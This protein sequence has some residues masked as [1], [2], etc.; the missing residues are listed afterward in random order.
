VVSCIQGSAITFIGL[1]VD[2]DDN[3]NDGDDESYYSLNF[4]YPVHINLF[5]IL[6]T[7]GIDVIVDL[8]MW[9]IGLAEK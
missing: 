5:N 6:M 3:G 9:K 4:C 7:Y 8:Q 1:K 2:D